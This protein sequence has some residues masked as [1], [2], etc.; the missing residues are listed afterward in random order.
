MAD[1]QPADCRSG[2][3]GHPDLALFHLLGR[4]LDAAARP[5]GLPCRQC[6]RLP[7][8]RAGRYRGHTAV[9]ELLP[10]AGHNITYLLHPQFAA[11]LQRIAATIP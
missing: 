4:A 11:E 6:G 8:L 10:A 5:K 1:Q 3:A 7:R 2:A 9:Q